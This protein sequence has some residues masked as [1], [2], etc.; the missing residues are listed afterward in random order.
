MHDPVR[1]IALCGLVTVA[2]AACTSSGGLPV[3][4][5]VA[6]SGASGGGSSGSGGDT[7]VGIDPPVIT[8]PGG[9]APIGPPRATIVTPKPGRL[10]VHPVGA[11]TVEGSVSGRRVTIRLTWWSGV[12]PCSVLDSIDVVRTGSAIVLTIR[13]GADQRGVACI[14]LAMLKG[15]IVDLG[16]LAPGSY[17][18]S[19]G[20]DAPPILVVVD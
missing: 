12:A 18:I 20:G 8:G 2:G 6:P 10:D 13:E 17:T 1:A 5:T 4:A 19:A 16:E 3:P 15:A 7:G 14:D 11:S 9:A